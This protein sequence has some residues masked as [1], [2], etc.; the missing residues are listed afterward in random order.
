[1]MKQ[2]LLLGGVTLGCGTGWTAP[3][4]RADVAANPSLVAHFDCDGFR[5]TA[6]GKAILD[7]VTEP[8][9]AGKLDALQAFTSFDPRTQ[10]HGLTCYATGQKSENGVLLLYADF[11]SNRL[12]ALAE[13]MTDYHRVTSGSH[14]IHSWIDENKKAEGGEP[15]VSAAIQ[16]KRVIFGKSEAAVASA[17]EVLDGKTPS[18]AGDKALPELGA[19]G[20]GD[21]LQGVVSKFDFAS[22]DPNSAILKGSKM[23]RIHVGENGDQLQAVVNFQA[24]DDDKATQ[25]AA[26]AQGLIALGKLQQDKPAALKLANSVSIKQDGASVIATLSIAEA[27]VVGLIKTGAESAKSKSAQANSPPAP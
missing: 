13:T 21:F 26:I 15:H 3:L 22:K 12:V 1:M 27:D 16:G 7:Q 11:D 25:I 19:A 10:W 23:V 24:S 14:F 9:I 2:I 8:E 18:L 4:Q 17:L 6:I 5:S 20:G